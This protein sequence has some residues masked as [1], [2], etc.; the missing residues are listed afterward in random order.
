LKYCKSNAI[1]LKKGSLTSKQRD[2][3]DRAAAANIPEFTPSSFALAIMNLV[4]AN[5]LVRFI[6]FF[7][8]KAKI[9]K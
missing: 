7:F 1:A 5:D 2:A 6:Q 4:V 8:L 3:I 9:K